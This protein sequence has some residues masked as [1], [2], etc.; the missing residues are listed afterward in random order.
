VFGFDIPPLAIR[1]SAARRR[2]SSA[3]LY[4]WKKGWV[5]ISHA[6]LEEN[7]GLEEVADGIWSLYFG[8]LLLGRFHEDELK[9]HG[10]RLN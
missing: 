5:N 9:L 1:L 8:P 7:V 3:S 2:S 6:L 10:A 4:R